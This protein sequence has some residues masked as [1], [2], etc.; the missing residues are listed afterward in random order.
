M[1]RTL[2]EELSR[3]EVFT[4]G[5][6]VDEPIKNHTTL[7]IGG[8]AD[9]FVSPATLVS[10]RHLLCL[11]RERGVNGV[12]IGGGSNILASDRGFRG[13]VVSTTALTAL[14]II[15]ESDVEV[16]IFVEA[17][18]SLQKLLNLAKEQGYS[19]IEGLAGIPG[20]VGGAV[21]GNAGSFGIEIADVVESATVMHR[22]GTIA[23]F[24]R[25]KIGFRYRSTDIPEGAVILSLNLRLTKDD[26]REVERRAQECLQEKKKKQPLTAWS[27]GCVFKNPPGTSAGRLID[28]AQCKGMRKGAIEVSTLHANY[29]V[30]TGKGTAAD[31]L[32]LMHDVRE[33][34]SERFHIEL[35]P[36]V[37]TIGTV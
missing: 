29:F 12:C 17:G 1:P 16:R 36:E 19:G 14:D 18:V 32:G 4:G 35:E 27:A 9:L 37:R 34:V 5:V 22:D 26:A 13:V 20:T 2:V 3:E 33:R 25:E 24:D 28:E 8:P 6:L 10:M 21:R 11:L 31:F 15:E 23:L 30:N 7:R